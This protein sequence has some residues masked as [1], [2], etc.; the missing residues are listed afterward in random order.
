MT[1]DGKVLGTHKGIIRYTV[2]QRRGL[3][4]ALPAPLYVKRKD[5]ISNRVVLSPEKDLYSS[6]LDAENINIIVSD[7]LD[8]PLKVK[9]R[10]RYN[11]PE[12]PATV[13]QTDEN[14]FHVHFD[15][16]QRAI[17][18]G[19]AVVLYDGDIVVGGGTII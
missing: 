14:R 16:P 6:D 11:Q 13:T 17:A 7:K 9:A 18:K 4:L 1:E 10:I 2:G 19:Q 5:L 3:G 8:V 12:Q 15:V